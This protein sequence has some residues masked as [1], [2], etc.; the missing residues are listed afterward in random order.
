[1]AN[2]K[3]EPPNV[4]EPMREPTLNRRLWALYLRAG[5]TR[6]TFAKE[7]N[8]GYNL[9]SYWDTGKT[10]MSLAHLLKACEL[11]RVTVDSVAFGRGPVSAERSL[12]HDEIVALLDSVQATDAQCKALAEH[13]RSDA[14]HFQRMTPAFVQR[15]VDA[16]QHTRDEGQDHDA[17]R[18]YAAQ[19]ASAARD[20]IDA[21]AHHYKPVNAKALQQAAAAAFPAV[22]KLRKPRKR[23]ARVATAAPTKIKRG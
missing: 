16:Y 6:G 14:G 4:A 17:A 8:V 23:T 12:T 3:Y 1:M 2:Q 18:T 10:T 13:S 20:S 15:F 7:L 9:V 19:E 5:Y 11:L 21:M 22:V